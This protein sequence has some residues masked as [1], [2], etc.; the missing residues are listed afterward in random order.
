MRPRLL[1]VE[2]FPAECRYAR[3]EHSL[4]HGIVVSDRSLAALQ[5]LLA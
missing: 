3:R 2:R 1:H 5:R 4:R